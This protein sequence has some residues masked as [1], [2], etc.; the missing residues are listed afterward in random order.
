[1][2][3][4]PYMSI[5]YLH[6]FLRKDIT[7]STTNATVPKFT[8]CFYDRFAFGPMANTGAL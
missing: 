7:F 6:K 8:T 1:M 4:S 2:S 3:S 5:M